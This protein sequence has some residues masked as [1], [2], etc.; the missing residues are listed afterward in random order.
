[1]TTI[2]QENSS[3]ITMSVII[4]TTAARYSTLVSNSPTIG[5][6]DSVHLNDSYP[7][8]N[9]TIDYAESGNFT[10]A[11]PTKKL[12]V[13]FQNRRAKWRKKENV[14]NGH[15]ENGVPKKDGQEPGKSKDCGAFSIENLLAASRVPRGRRPNAKYPRVQVSWLICSFAN[16]TM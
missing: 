6:N 14:K 3:H 10:S 7:Q 12:K 11:T 5:S 9:Y 16:I 1:M 2:P 15:P 13:W 8:N 4:R